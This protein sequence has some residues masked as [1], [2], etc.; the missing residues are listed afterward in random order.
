LLLSDTP[1]GEHWLQNFG[2]SERATAT[3]LLDALELVGQDALRDIEGL[4]AHARA[5]GPRYGDKLRAR[6]TKALNESG[7]HDESL[8]APH[9]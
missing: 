9:Q 6:L 7:W 4:I 2:L 8:G 5:V 3:L 1:R